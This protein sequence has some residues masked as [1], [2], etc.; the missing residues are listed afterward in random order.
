MPPSKDSLLVRLFFSGL[1]SPQEVLNE[2]K[3]QRQLHQQQLETYQQIEPEAD[4][5]SELEG[6]SIDFDREAK[7]WRMTLEFGLAYEKM[8]LNWLDET[9]ARIE[10][11]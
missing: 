9:I 4:P 6:S 8:Y 1:R 11:L 2:L 5:Q 10:S 7:F 3:F